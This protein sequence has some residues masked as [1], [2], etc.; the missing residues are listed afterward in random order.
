MSTLEE[1]PR[2]V[3]DQVL[4]DLVLMELSTIRLTDTGS[5]FCAG[6]GAARRH[7]A[8]AIKDHDDTAAD[9]AGL[10]QT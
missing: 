3:I 2:R 6:I 1:L 10:V 8:A 5:Q 9:L 4:N 7:L